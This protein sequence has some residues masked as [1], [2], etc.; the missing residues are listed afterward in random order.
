MQTNFL[1]V[2]DRNNKKIGSIYSNNHSNIRQ[3]YISVLLPSSTKHNDSETNNKRTTY[4][5]QKDHLAGKKERLRTS[6][7]KLSI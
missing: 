5:Q 6:Y 7:L 3:Q 4:Q 2:G 1:N